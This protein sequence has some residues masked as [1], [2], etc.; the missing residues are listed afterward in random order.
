[1][2]GRDRAARNPRRIGATSAFRKSSSPTILVLVL[3]LTIV[4]A[5][6]SQSRAADAA[7]DMSI[8]RGRII[9]SLKTSPKDEEVAAILAQQK[10]DGSFSDLDYSDT[11]VNDAWQPQK[12]LYR[13]QTMTSAYV[14]PAGKYAK[15][16]AIEHAVMDGVQYWLTNDI[17]NKNWFFNEIRVPRLLACVSLVFWNEY[18]EAQKSKSLEII[19]R[20]KL[21]G[22]GTNLIWLSEIVAMRGLLQNNPALFKSAYDKIAS[23]IRTVKQDGPQADN[24]FTFHGPLLYTWGYGSYY[25]LD[26]SRLAAIVAGTQFAYP[27]EKTDMIAGWTLDG[28]QWM[29]R[30]VGEDFGA[31]GRETGRKG[32][33][34]SILL[35]TGAN[36]EKLDSTRGKE[37]EAMTA[38]TRGD[39]AASPLVGNKQFW[40]ADIMVQHRAGYY[41]SARMYSTRT[42]NTECGNFEG[43]ENFYIADGC[44]VLMKDGTEYFDI[45]PVWDWQRIPGTTVDL[46][47]H[48]G[49]VPGA[50]DYTAASAFIPD[51]GKIVYPSKESFVGGV[52]DGMYGVSG[53]KFT[54]DGLHVNKGWFFFDNEYVCLG[55]DLSCTTSD[56]VV[57]TL[58]Q[59]YL[60]GEVA[61]SDGDGDQRLAP[62]AHEIEG[63]NWVL[64]DHVGYV[65]AQPTHVEV[66]NQSQSGSWHKVSNAYPDVPMQRDIFKAWIDHDQHPT[67]GAYA[68]TVIPVT[69]TGR[70]NAFMKA[71][72]IVVTSNTAELQSVWH[73][74][75]RRGGAIFYKAGTAELRPGLRV[76]VDQPGMAM[77][78][79]GDGGAT[80]SIA[81]PENKPMTAHVR[82]ERDGKSSEV[83]VVLP[84]GDHAGSTVTQPLTF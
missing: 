84:A 44:N 11:I 50:K 13:L 7:A 26:N 40:R 77:L 2:C 68:Y 79:E 39:A 69:D 63:L 59:C 49:P 5:T 60:R 1:M 36:L 67:N 15:S 3:V 75:L 32:K 55:S 72:S 35:D 33:C 56:P 76:S 46:V 41:A 43:L 4:G 34:T 58:N 52:S 62:G 24:S 6:S 82:V 17:R 73:S 31:I 21:G 53:G 71:P 45:F 9:D 29:G 18:T 64:H 25:L 16:E 14:S 8:V 83:D 66:D 80:V 30:G 70:L 61:V 74:Q 48:F 65:F 23:E 20:A 57:T 42:T 78:A 51:R 54:R 19:G 37:I 22:V 27:P 38:R 12:H 47:P 28:A 81:N 10:P